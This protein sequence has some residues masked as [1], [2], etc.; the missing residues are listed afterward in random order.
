[1]NRREFLERGVRTAGVLSAG[2]FGIVAAACQPSADDTQPAQA[3]ADSPG[4]DALGAPPWP[5]A[6]LQANEGELLISGGRRA[7]MRIKVDSRIAIG[8]TMSMI[9]SVVDPGASIPV[10]LHRNED[11][12]IFIH[13]GSGIVTLGE[14]R[15]PSSAGAVLYGPRNIWHGVENTGSTVLTWC[16]VYSPPGFEQFFREVGVPPGKEDS[17][18]SRERVLAIAEKYGMIFRE[19]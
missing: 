16:A 17:A 2:S 8:A 4:I 1:L 12:L 19:A 15:I 14:E 13:T 6:V 18:P 10:H 7:P 3:R 9:V 5:G 11:E